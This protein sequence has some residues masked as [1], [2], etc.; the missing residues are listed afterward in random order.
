MNLL[1]L[2]FDADNL[3]MILCSGIREVKGGC[4]I[5]SIAWNGGDKT[6]SGKK[7]DFVVIAYLFFV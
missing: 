6:S 3:E 1:L 7:I 5:V 2:K 4:F